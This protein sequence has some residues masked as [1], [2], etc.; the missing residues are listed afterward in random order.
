[1]L[2]QEFKEFFEKIT[3][4]SEF[5]KLF[6]CIKTI[7]KNGVTSSWVE[8]FGSSSE[9]KLTANE[10]RGSGGCTGFSLPYS[11]PCLSVEQKI[12]PR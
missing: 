10:N 11:I 3:L 4:K 1:M 12:D 5:T 8:T 6:A 7:L 9:H 2:V